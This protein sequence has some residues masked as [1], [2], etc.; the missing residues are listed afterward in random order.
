MAKTRY[1]LATMGK[2]KKASRVVVSGVAKNILEAM[3]SGA[4]TYQALM[5][6]G[7]PR[8]SV[9]MAVKRLRDAGFVV[10]EPIARRF[11]SGVARTVSADA[12]ALFAQLFLMRQE[13]DV[14]GKGEI[15]GRMTRLLKHTRK[16]VSADALALALRVIIDNLDECLI[17]DSG[18]AAEHMEE[19][20]AWTIRCLI[21]AKYK[22][23]AKG[24]YAITT[25]FCKLTGVLLP[26]DLQK[27]A[28]LFVNVGLR[29][30]VAVILASQLSSQRE[31]PALSR[32]FLLAAV[33][34]NNA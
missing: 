13:L 34:E 23:A 3:C 2:G 29:V 16:V 1:A 9:Y 24:L 33:D 28:S 27:N 21:D 31:A 22:K 12:L 26:T 25:A 6:S 17:D 20:L 18:D 11:L 10:S 5:D 4:S 32:D 14:F 7:I 19:D 15:L 30:D 8:N